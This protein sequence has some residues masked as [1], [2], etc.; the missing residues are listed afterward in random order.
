MTKLVSTLSGKPASKFAFGTMQFGGGSSEDDAATVYGMCRGAGI[1]VFDTAF[2]Y[3]NGASERQLGKLIAKERDD[4][5]VMSKCA[6]PA[7]ST[8]ENISAQFDES[9]KRLNQDII[10]VLFL[11]RWD[12]DTP[13][14]NTLTTLAEFKANGTIRSIGV[15]NF[16]A[17]Q[18][19]KAQGVAASL[20]ISIDVIQPMYSIVKRQVEVEILPMAISEGIATTPYSPL[21]GGLLTGKYQRGESGR[22]KENP[23][24]TARYAE[25]EAFDSAEALAK[26]AGD[27]GVHPATLAVAW[28]AKNPAITATLIS[29]KNADQFAPSLQATT[30]KLSDT[31]YGKISALSRTPAPATDR[32]E[33][34][35][36]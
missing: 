28:V 20:G 12:N 8:P 17:W 25:Q 22:L 24:Y 32:L 6:H 35:T 23:E 2:G 30:Y 11:H 5:V 4:V 19:M 13:L 3:T 36:K 16:S 33:E 1:N 27:M 31:D 9:R 26:L 7:P 29:G 18:V 10:D 14:E 21:G 15:S 34:Q